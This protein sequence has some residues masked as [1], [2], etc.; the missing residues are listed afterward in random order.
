LKI[1]RLRAGL[2]CK[3]K[4]GKGLSTRPKESA[5]YGR[6]C[7]GFLVA[8][9]ALA[10]AVELAEEVEVAVFLVD[11]GDEATEGEKVDFAGVVGAGGLVEAVNEGAVVDCGGFWKIRECVHDSSMGKRWEII[12]KEE[13]GDLADLEG[14][15]EVVGL[16]GLG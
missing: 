2:D 11:L 7:G 9:D 3:W 8:L 1:K 15:G 10:G 4:Q 14:D 6:F 12:G 16:T 5:I 13:E